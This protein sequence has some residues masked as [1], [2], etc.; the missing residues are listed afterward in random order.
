MRVHLFADHEDDTQRV[1]VPAGRSDLCHFYGTDAQ[2]PHIHLAQSLE[3]GAGINI[4]DKSTRSAQSGAQGRR[5]RRRA[6]VRGSAQAA[7][8]LDCEGLRSLKPGVVTLWPACLQP[9]CLQSQL[10]PTVSPTRKKTVQTEPSAQ[11][12]TEK[13]LSWI[14][15]GVIQCGVA[16]F[17][18]ATCLSSQQSP[19]TRMNC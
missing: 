18:E 10:P 7:D 13:L 16:Q 4:H 15:S 1:Y 11:T 8:V 6:E 9:A 3:Q 5:E 19:T 17:T 2:R 12:E 14:T